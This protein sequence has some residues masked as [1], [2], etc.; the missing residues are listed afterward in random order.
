MNPTWI[1]GRQIFGKL[2]IHGLNDRA[3]KKGERITGI[4]SYVKF[5]TI[6]FFEEIAKMRA[7]RRIW[8]TVL[9]EK[10]GAKN[11]RSLF[12]S[13]LSL[14]MYPVFLFHGSSVLAF[15]SS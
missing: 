7:A 14:G 12:K 1:S 10:Y 9:R 6:N 15:H 8:A 2:L 11:E 3:W 4:Q 13:H 5:K